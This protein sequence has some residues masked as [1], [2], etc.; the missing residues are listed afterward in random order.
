MTKKEEPI[1]K[2]TKKATAII[3][4]EVLKINPKASKL[5]TL[6]QAF[7]ILMTQWDMEIGI[8]TKLN[9]PTKV[10]LYRDEEIP[11]EWDFENGWDEKQGDYDWNTIYR[12]VLEDIIKRRLYK[13]PKLGKRAQKQKD[14]QLAKIKAEKAKIE[15]KKLEQE[16]KVPLIKLKQQRGILSSKINY[17]KK[18]KRS[19]TEIAALEIELNNIKEQIKNY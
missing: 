18:T 3:I 8:V 16:P 1:E 13:R 11:A 2:Y 5:T 12:E 15:N 9:Q 6:D 10:S 14:E 7:V 17:W 4:S 19:T